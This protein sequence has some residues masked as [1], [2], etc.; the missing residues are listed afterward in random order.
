[1]WDC[2]REKYFPTNT[3]STFSLFVASD[4]NETL[5]TVPEDLRTYPLLFLLLS[6]IYSIIAHKYLIT[7]QGPTDREST[8]GILSA[9]A[10]IWY[11]FL[12]FLPF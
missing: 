12:S 8:G 6:S 10:D 3:N 9:L 7:R 11:F 5:S 4:T 2:V 1:M